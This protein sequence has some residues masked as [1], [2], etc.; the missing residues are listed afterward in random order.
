MATRWMDR[1]REREGEKYFDFFV[2][3]NHAW[4][5]AI[6]R[7]PLHQRVGEVRDPRGY[8]FPRTYINP[9]LSPF[10]EARCAAG[11]PSSD[12]DNF[13]DGYFHGKLYRATWLRHPLA[14]SERPI[15]FL[16][17]SLFL[18]HDFDGIN[19]ICSVS[20]GW[21]GVLN[22]LRRIFSILCF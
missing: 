21:V 8:H 19:N 6:V 14:K 20:S 1:E 7:A 11:S 13:M 2:P 18:L 9:R 10:H 12:L 16:S 5:V 22:F 15:S 4:N 17:L 3:S